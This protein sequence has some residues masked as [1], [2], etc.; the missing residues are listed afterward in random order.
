MSEQDHSPSACADT[1]RAAETAVLDP[2]KWEWWASRDEENYTV[3]PEGSRED[4]VAAALCDFDGEPFHVVEACKGSMSSYL[5][6]GQR[7]IEWMQECADDNGAF[8]DDKYCELTG[9]AEA[10]AAAEADA[11]AVL[12]DW[13]A[14]HAAIFPTPWAFRATRNAEWISPAEVGAQALSRTASQQA[15]PASDT[16]G[17][18]FA[19]Q[20][21]PKAASS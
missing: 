11:K 21:E 4:V 19:K 13:F 20:N 9:S 15:A 5:P 7:I 8:G 17:R 2:E 12:A 10:I 1:H 14:R 18:D 3:G 6:S 16:T